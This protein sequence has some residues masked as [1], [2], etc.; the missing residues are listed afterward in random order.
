M[1]VARRD[2]GRRRLLAILLAGSLLSGGLAGCGILPP[3]PDKTEEATVEYGNVA[4]AVTAAVPR[5]VAVEDPG[6]WRNGF[7]Y[8]AEFSLVTD[9]AE[10]FTRDELDATVEAIW[11]SLPWEPNTITLY[12]AETTADGDPVDLRAAAA[13]LGPLGTTNAGQGGVNLTGMKDRYGAWTA[14]E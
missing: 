2:I 7:G 4:S 3:E 13:E 1:N 12:A 14:P 10:P 5:I 11:Q 8:G 6:R 9:S